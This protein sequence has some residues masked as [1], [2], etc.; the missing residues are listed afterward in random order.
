MRQD[1]MHKTS[2][3]ELLRDHRPEAIKRRLQLP[4]K[5][6]NISNA[7]LGGID[8]CVTTFAVV[9]SSVGAGLPSS[10]ALIMGFANLAAD[11]FSMAVSNYESVKT[12][13][14]LIEGIRKSEE[15]HIL[16]IPKGEREEIRQIFQTKGFSGETL[17][18]IIDTICEDKELWVETMLTEEHGVHRGAFRPLR[19]AAVTLVSFVFVGAIPLIP[20]FLSSLAM[21]EQFILS[22]FLAAMMFFLIGAVK[23][24]VLSRPVLTSGL[25]TLLTGSTAA[26]LAFFAGYLLRNIFGIDGL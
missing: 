19:S 22:A 14:E 1:K 20:F 8:G 26:G 12:E 23:G 15:Q 4:V 17:E 3:E 16:K 2:R 18:K 25:S 10:V 5:S 13:S 21:Q 6:Q 11:G 7:V 24:K 9:S